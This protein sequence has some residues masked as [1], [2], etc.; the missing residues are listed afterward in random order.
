MPGRDGL[1]KAMA[2]ALGLGH[3]PVAPGTWA[4]AAAAAAYVL[5]DRLP[6]PWAPVLLGALLLGVFAAGLALVP[7]AEAAYGS[8]DPRQFVLDE[9]AGQWLTCLLFAW[10][11]PLA[12]AAAAFVAFRVFDI[13]KPF[14]IKRLETLPGGWGVMSDDL[15]AGAYAAGTLWLLARLAAGWWPAG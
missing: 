8:K 7:A 2:S 13:V 9:V 5:I 1:V 3:L 15:A 12:T 10:R 6:A 4:S 14:P 11:G